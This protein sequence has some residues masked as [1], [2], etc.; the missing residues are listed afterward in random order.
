MWP[1][2]HT[3]AGHERP[4]EFWENRQGKHQIDIQG[5][6]KL[7]PTPS[8]QPPGWK[9]IEVVDKEG[10]APKHPNQRFYDKKTGRLVQKGL[11]QVVAMWPTPRAG[12]PGSRKPGT[13]GKV[14]NEEVKKWPTPTSRDHKDTGKAVQ[15]GRVPVNALLGRA[16]WPTPSACS[17][18]GVTGGG[19]SGLAG[20][21][22]NRQKL[23]NLLGKKEGKK[24]GSQSLNPDWV[25]WLMGLPVGWSNVEPLFG[26]DFMEGDSVD[27]WLTN[28]RVWWVVDPADVGFVPRVT[29]Q[30]TNRVNRLKGLGNGQVPQCMAFAW[31][32]LQILPWSETRVIRKVE[33]EC[34]D[35]QVKE[36][37]QTSLF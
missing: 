29:P 23:Y 1:T 32:N 6:V 18:V 4:K 28:Q 12:N 21:S 31:L 26:I 20:G 5:A 9:N 13:G 25:E 22:G 8:A 34:S 36:V 11:E 27:F 17:R 3:D 2:P 16:V 37:I 30:K 35:E 33:V 24:M 19:H 15:E 10:V 7:Y 14:L